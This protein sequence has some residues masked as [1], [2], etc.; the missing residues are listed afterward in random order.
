MNNSLPVLLRRTPL[1]GSSLVEVIG[2]GIKAMHGHNT[3]V[4]LKTDD[5]LKGIEIHGDARVLRRLFLN[6]ANQLNTT[7][8]AGQRKF[9][10]RQ[11]LNPDATDW[12]WLTPAMVVAY[13]EQSDVL[14][15]HAADVRDAL[16]Y[17]VT[18]AQEQA[19]QAEA[20]ANTLG[21][22]LE[23][24]RQHYAIEELIDEDGTP[25]WG[26]QT[27]IAEALGISNAGASNRRRIKAA[28]YELLKDEAA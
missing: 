22:D 23:L 5:G 15:P 1:N 6:L 11:R 18:P 3:I 14:R 19:A 10:Q 8:P 24:I 21:D 28:L 25:A 17:L 9:E 26:A 2:A 16:R 20:Q 4:W 13:F 12:D 27:R 7:T